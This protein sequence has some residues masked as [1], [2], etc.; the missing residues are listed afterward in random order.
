MREETSKTTNRRP[1]GFTL[2]ELLVVIGIIALLISILLPSLNQA[3]RQA[4]QVKCAA[5][6]R[7]MGLA[8]TMYINDW[9]YYPGCR[10]A[11]NGANYAVWPTRLRAYMK[12]S[13]GVFRCP[14]QEGNFEW[15][16]NEP[17]Q[18]P[19][20]TDADTG[21]GYRKG[22]N[23]LVDGIRKITYGYNDWGAYDPK[24]TGAKFVAGAD[25]NRHPGLGADLNNAAS[26]QARVLK[27]SLVRNAT[28]L[29]VIADNSP[30]PGWGYTYNLDPNEPEEF[31][32][33][34]HKEG[35]NVLH[36]DGHVDWNR[37]RDIVLYN[38]DDL[39]KHPSSIGIPLQKK[40]W[41]SIAP[42]WNA[43]NMP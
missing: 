30:K 21:F 8:L 39:N 34:I 40:A 42:Q 20:A 4:N 35:A 24:F 25:A 15:V 18:A 27:A 36:G 38:F 29:I 32:G 2:V 19:F 6:L 9:K 22:E 28:A 12:G 1:A 31:P 41:A 23:L 11:S 26:P 7:Q 16:P 43:D 33:K 3:R 10:N 13:M 5:N 17:P 37:Q 14:Q